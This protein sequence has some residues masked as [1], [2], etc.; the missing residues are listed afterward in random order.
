MTRKAYSGALWV[1]DAPGYIDPAKDID[2]A[3]TRMESAISTLDEETTLITGGDFTKN[4][5]RIRKER[6]LLQEIGL[7]QPGTNPGD[8]KLKPKNEDMK[9]GASNE[10]D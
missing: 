7:W 9:E 8:K 5:P 1:G 4:L 2:A 3:V 10:A 6:K